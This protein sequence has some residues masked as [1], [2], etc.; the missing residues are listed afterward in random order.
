MS[1]TEAPQIDVK[2]VVINETKM[3]G[4]FQK[5]PVEVLTLEKTRDHLKQ[6]EYELALAEDS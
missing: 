2:L 1:E 6:I 3:I 4:F 5:D